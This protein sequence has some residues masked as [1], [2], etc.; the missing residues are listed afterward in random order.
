MSERSRPKYSFSKK[1]DGGEFLNVAA[2]QD[3]TGQG[4]TRK[5]RSS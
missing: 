4:Q 2:W 3:R 5:K 1:V